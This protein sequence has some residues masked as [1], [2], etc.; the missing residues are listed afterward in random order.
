LLVG[1]AKAKAKQIPFGNDKEN[2][3]PARA[4]VAAQMQGFFGF[5]SE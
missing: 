2:S 3:R 4:V 1:K 5:A